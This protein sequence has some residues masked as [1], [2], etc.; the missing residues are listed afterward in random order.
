M[1]CD[2]L[3]VWNGVEGGKKV[4]EREICILMADLHCCMAETSTSL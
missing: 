3:E 2:N 1:F 4:R